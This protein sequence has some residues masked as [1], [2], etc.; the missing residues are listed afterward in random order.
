[1]QSITLLTV[2]GSN[3]VTNPFIVTEV[4]VEQDDDWTLASLSF[5]KLVIP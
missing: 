2:V 5:A 1:M 4:Y 3:G